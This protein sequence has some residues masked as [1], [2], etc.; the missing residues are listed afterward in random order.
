MKNKDS[1]DP[2]LQS[3]KFEELKGRALQNKEVN[4]ISILE[5]E[6]EEKMELWETRGLRPPWERKGTSVRGGSL[7]WWRI[8]EAL[9][10]CNYSAL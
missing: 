5:E 7:R 10:G 2:H 1:R 6:I 3:S 4:L 8:W 9:R